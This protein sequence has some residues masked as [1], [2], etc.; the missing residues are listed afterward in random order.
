MYTNTVKDIKMKIWFVYF[1]CFFSIILLIN[2]CGKPETK[3]DLA[4]STECNPPCWNGIT[5]GQ[6]TKD[7]AISIMRAEE[8]GKE[9]NLSIDDNGITW[10]NSESRTVYRLEFQDNYVQ[11]I[12][13]QLEG[14]SI[15]QIIEMFGN[16]DY[17]L[18]N[19]GRGGGYGI[20]L[21]FPHEGMAFLGNLGTHLRISE[22]AQVNY[23]YFIKPTDIEG[24]LEIIHGK[25][26]VSTLLSELREWQGFG[27][28]EP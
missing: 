11:L 15:N 27:E 3:S 24:E 21:Y 14:V 9:D 17:F 25:S 16:P 12:R 26:W 8:I 19:V 7:V 4:G 5:P 6:T 28:I 13:F 18:T 20:S 22:N 2:G 1:I 23:A 10:F